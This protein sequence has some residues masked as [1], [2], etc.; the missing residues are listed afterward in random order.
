VPARWAGSPTALATRA[1]LKLHLDRGAAAISSRAGGSEALRTPWRKARAAVRD[2]RGSRH[3]INAE[4]TENK[5]TLG[6]K[7]ALRNEIEAGR[8][9][10]HSAYPELGES[11]IEKLLDALAQASW[12]LA[13]S[14][15]RSGLSGQPRRASKS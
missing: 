4:P 13:V 11:S 2:P 15:R 12:G 8:R 10:A 5:L 6:S 1:I 14:R 3:L 7:G 9:M